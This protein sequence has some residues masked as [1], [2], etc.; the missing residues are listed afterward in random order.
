MQVLLEPGEG[1]GLVAVQAEAV[2]QGG[3]QTGPVL[4]AGERAGADHAEAPGDLLAS[5]PG[6]QPIA[7]DVDAGVGVLPE[8]VDP[9][10]QT[11]QGRTLKTP[12]G[13]TA[14][15][16]GGT[17]PASHQGW[18]WDLTIPG[19]G[20]HD[21]YVVADT[22]MGFALI[23]A[24]AALLVHNDGSPSPVGTVFRFGPYRFQIYSNDH[25]PAHGHLLGPGIGGD[26]IQIG[27]NGKPLD[28]NVTLTPAEQKVID[29]NLGTIRKAI[30]KYMA[31]YR[32]TCG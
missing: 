4:A 13:T 18:M 5:G 3:D 22:R 25:G 17:V 26:G 14:T 23:P 30:G 28:P 6:Q 1:T 9:G 15:A 16:D 2:F 7:L 32:D 21:F 8:A 10:R 29:E 19:D 27:Q 20:D 11:P 31:W 12:D 24:Y